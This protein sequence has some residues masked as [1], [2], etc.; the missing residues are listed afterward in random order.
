MNQYQKVIFV[1][2]SDT[3]RSPMAEVVLKAMMMDAPISVHSRGLVVLFPEP[4][5]QKAEAILISN[6]YGSQKHMSK[7]LTQE[8]IGD[9]TGVLLL[10][11]ESSQKE[12]VF[13]EYCN[14]KHVFTLREFLGHQGDLRALYGA[15]LIEYG[16]FYEVLKGLMEELVIKLSEEEILE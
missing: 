16:L 12:K 10:T 7:P 13:Q 1:D 4:M 5:N 3:T 8:D 2:S 15:P 9:G 6:G 14:L 11:M